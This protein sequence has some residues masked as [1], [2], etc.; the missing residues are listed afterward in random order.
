MQI[1][2]YAGVIELS[3][4]TVNALKTKFRGVNVDEELAKLHLWLLKNP[5]RRPKRYIR[6]IE[7]WLSRSPRKEMPRVV[8]SWWTTEHGTMEQAQ[9]CGVMPRAGE[10]W[11]RLRERIRQAMSS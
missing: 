7:S 3:T 6:F 11:P 9:R 2:T 4:D 8:S 10:D 5:S 1:Y